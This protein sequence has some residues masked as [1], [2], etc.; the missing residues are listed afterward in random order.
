MFLIEIEY[1]KTLKTLIPQ[2]PWG[3]NVFNWNK[4]LK[5]LKTLKSLGGLMF[6]I[7]PPEAWGILMGL[8]FLMPPELKT[9]KTLIPQKPWGINV[10][11]WNKYLKTLKT[12]IPQKPWGINVFNVFNSRGSGPRIPGFWGI[13]GI[14]VFKVW[15]PW[16]NVFKYLFQLKTLI[17]QK[18]WGINV[19]NWNKYLKTL[20]TL[21][22]QSLGGLM[23]LMWNKS[24][25]SGPRIPG[26]WGI[27][28][29]NVFNVFNVFTCF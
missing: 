29:I 5:T 12:L 17:P 4:Y 16:F 15:D 7:N 11:N 26:V 9:L 13:N 24:R 27:N 20:K 21:I 10:F 19:F 3:I 23:F 18:P 14:N 8:M 6:P 22:P 1:L 25:G 28:G 2:K